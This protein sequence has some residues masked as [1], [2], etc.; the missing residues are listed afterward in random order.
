MLDAHVGSHPLGRRLVVVSWVAVLGATLLVAGCG[1]ASPRSGTGTGT[2]A[3]SLKDPVAA[4]FKFSRCMRQHGLPSFPDPKVTSRPGQQSIAMVVPAGVGNSPHFA[5]AQKACNSIMPGPSNSD[6][7]AQA[8]QQ[9][10]QKQ[11][12]LSFAR[13]VRQHGIN[14]F[15]DPDAQGQLT[16]Q[17]LSTAGIDVHASSVLTAAR[18]CIPASDGQ[19]NAAAIAAAENRSP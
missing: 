17:L 11:G 12:L 1:S 3:Q 9:R 18:A 13:C 2:S 5:A 16:P 19:V 6:L 4:A 7:A 10:V 8:Q 14:N 15:P